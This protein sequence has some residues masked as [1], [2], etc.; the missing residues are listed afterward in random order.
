MLISLGDHKPDVQ[1]ADVW[2]AANATLIGRV[3]LCEGSNVWYGAVLR[4][5]N[6]PIVIGARTNIQ[7]LSV[8]HTDPGFPLNIGPDCTIGHQAML[9]GC[10]VGE[11]T[12][13]GIG[14]IVLNGARI[15]R[16]CLIGA[17][18]LVPEGAEIPDRSLVVGLP[19][20]VK[21]ELSDEEV[22]RLLENTAQYSRRAGDYRLN[23]KV[24]SE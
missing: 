12:M 6:E 19:G 9:H 16:H 24:I 2:V 21:R 18:A 5:D 8:L 11:G 22:S 10:T 23:A 17:G 15:G 4:A 13:I 20:K 14:A 1:S 3:V 7:D